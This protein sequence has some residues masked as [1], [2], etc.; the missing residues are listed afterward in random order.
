MP[1]QILE[2]YILEPAT[3]KLDGGAMYGIIPKP[4]WNKKHP[5]DEFNRINL[6]LRLWLIKTSEKLVLVDTGIGDYHGEKFDARFDVKGGDSPLIQALSQLGFKKEDVTDLVIS[7]LHFDHVGGIGESQ[8]GQENLIPIFPAARCH[9]HKEHYTYSHNATERDKGSFHTHLFDSV[10]D[11][12]KENGLLHFYSG[13]EGELFSLDAEN[14]LKFKCSHGH[15]PWLMHPYTSDYIYLS[16]IIPTSHHLSIPW[17]MGYDINPGITT[18]N[19]KDFFKFIEKNN[20]KVIYEHDPEFWGSDL[21]EDVH[22]DMQ[23]KL[24]YK[25]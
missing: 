12:Y 4:L 9:V 20:L 19:K 18:E 17:V 1:L 24:A 15:T 13:E 23:N 8:D 21:K 16:D 10:L 7:H 5:A 2:N 3:F 22:F 11:Y 6:A 25:I 14:T